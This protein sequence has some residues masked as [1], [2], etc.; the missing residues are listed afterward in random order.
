[1]LSRWHTIQEQAT[2]DTI[3]RIG[4]VIPPEGIQLGADD[5]VASA[6]TIVDVKPGWNVFSRSHPDYE[7]VAATGCVYGE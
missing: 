1:M 5:L 4:E 2:G 3:T 6:G 7:Y